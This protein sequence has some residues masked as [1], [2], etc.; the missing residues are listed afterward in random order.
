MSFPA[1]LCRDRCFGA[2]R[3]I[4][5][6]ETLAR[7]GKSQ[8][9]PISSFQHNP[10]EVTSRVCTRNERLSMYSVNARGVCYHSRNHTASGYEETK[11]QGLHLFPTRTK[12]SG[13][14]IYYGQKTKTAL[15]HFPS[16]H[17]SHRPFQGRAKPHRHNGANGERGGRA[18]AL[19]TCEDERLK[20]CRAILTR[21]C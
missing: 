3:V 16:T 15:I 12:T 11:T 18:F 2:R 21:I 17:T 14:K 5:A 9:Q 13:K 4:I 8:A 6:E 1:V 20:N 10:A 7:K 19:R